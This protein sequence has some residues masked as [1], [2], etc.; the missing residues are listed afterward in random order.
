MLIKLSGSGKCADALQRLEQFS[1]ARDQGVA[2]QAFERVD[3][4]GVYLYVALKDAP[5]P[6]NVQA[7]EQDLQANDSGAQCVLLE[8]GLH[9]AGAAAGHEAH[10]HYV[11][12]TDVRPEAEADFNAWYDTEHMPGLAAVPGTVQAQ[13][14]TACFGQP[15]YYATYDL[16][17]QETFGSPAWLQVRATD[18]SSRVRPNF[19]NTSRT[20]FR[21]IALQKED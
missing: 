19:V 6:A 10:W 18:W 12:E 17:T 5:D 3:A 4:A 14:Y 1:L 15:R 11:V 20:M 7:L 2:V 8:P 13:R 9:C 21:R 16:Q